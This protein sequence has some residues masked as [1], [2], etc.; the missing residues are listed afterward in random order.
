M[1]ECCTKHLDMFSRPDISLWL[2][3]I[4]YYIK[5]RKA[6]KFVTPSFLLV[7]LEEQGCILTIDTDTATYAKPLGLFY[8]EDQDKYM[9]CLCDFKPK[10]GRTC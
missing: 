3:I 8:N 5:K 6:M 10:T 1:H 2:D 4:N 7:I 9:I